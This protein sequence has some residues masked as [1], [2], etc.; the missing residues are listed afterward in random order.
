MYFTQEDYRKIED[1]LGKRTIRDT[2]FPLVGRINGSEKIP[3]IQDNTNKVIPFADFVSQ[4]TDM[5]LPDFYNVSVDLDRACLTLKAAVSLVPQGK[6]KLGLVITFHNE[7]GNWEIYQ[8]NGCSVNQWDSL[9]YWDNIFINAIK[10]FV[11]YPDEEDITGVRDGNRVFLK[12]K[13]RKYAPEEFSG[14]GKVILRKNLK[15][16][17]TCSLDDEDHFV[18]ILTQDMISQENTIYVIQYDF[19]LEG[20]S[21]VIPANS[22]LY[23]DGGTINNGRI[24]LGYTPLLNVTEL[25]DTGTASFYGKFNHGQVLVFKEEDRNYLRWWNGSQW[26]NLLDSVDY[27][28]LKGSI[29]ALVQKHNEEMATCYNYFNNLI[30]EVRDELNTEVEKLTGITDKLNQSIGDLNSKVDANAE[31]IAEELR[32]LAGKIEEYKNTL[33]GRIDTLVQENKNISDSVRINTEAIEGNTSAISE[34]ESKLNSLKEEIGENLQSELDNL[35]NQLNSHEEVI[36]GLDSRVSDLLSD[37]LSMADDIKTLREGV[38]SIGDDLDAYTEDLSTRIEAIE[39][40]IG[41][42]LISTTIAAE[43]Q[44]IRL[45]V[46]GNQLS[47]RDLGDRADAIDSEIASLK[48]MDKFLGTNCCRAIVIGAEGEGN[49]YTVASNP[50]KI[51]IPKYPDKTLTLNVG[52]TKYTYN[53]YN[54]I[55]VTVPTTTGTAPI[56]DNDNLGTEDTP[57]VIGIIR[58]GYGNTGNGWLGP[59]FS[60]LKGRLGNISSEV[61]AENP[62]VGAK[63]LD[64]DISVNKGYKVN[65]MSLIGNYEGEGDVLVSGKHLGTTSYSDGDVVSIALYMSLSGMSTTDPEGTESTLTLIGYITKD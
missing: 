45:G 42:W 57:V 17:D 18:N 61:T 11:P 37:V 51:A 12:F 21:V 64:M 32:L 54:D 19:D 20:K 39:S 60:S 23:F 8:F 22:V 2:Q 41:D 43:V 14:K 55:S 35:K 10:E 7:H 4:V 50:G 26:L 34:L 29:D 52:G 47:I 16:T 25:S 53:G 48:D 58:A 40:T 24:M 44:D 49:E 62:T 36:G 46:H 15:P 30:I 65:I 13:D 1:W 63:E 56:V 28:E 27:E 59:T 5:K 38:K 33:S 6:R 3:L 31:A 9:N